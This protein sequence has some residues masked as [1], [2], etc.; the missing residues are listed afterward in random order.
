MELLI[1]KHK[2]LQYGVH[3]GTAVKT[4]SMRRFI[5]KILPNGLAVFNINVIDSRIRL[6]AKL[7]ARYKEILLASRRAK[8]PVET[9]AKLI[10]ARA[11]VGR[12]PPG[13]LTNPSYELYYEPEVLFVTDPIAD[14]QAV[15][16]A[17]KSRIPVIALCNT[18][19]TLS[20][21]DLA[22][23]CNNRGRKAVALV[24]Y[25]LSREVLRERGVIKRR[26]EFKLSIK[27]FLES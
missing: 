23:P 20:N 21:V 1:D 19:N 2:Y 9:M 4:A 11:V 16:E 13:M 7:L 15:E 8:K 5:Y 18:F 10:E 27:D 6:A 24:L 25:L 26:S 17:V 22:I 3:I 12:F 14:S